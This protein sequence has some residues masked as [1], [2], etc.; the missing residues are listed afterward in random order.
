MKLRHSTDSRVQHSLLSVIMMLSKHEEAGGDVW[1]EKEK[2]GMFIKEL[3]TE[4]R[5]TQKE[6]ADMVHV[7]DKAVSKW[8][9]GLSVPALDLFR[10]LAAALDVSVVE[11]L[12]GQRHKEETIGLKQANAILESTIA[13]QKK[14]ILKKRIAFLFVSALLL[15][16]CMI[17]GRLLWNQGLLLDERGLVPADL[18]WQEQDMALDWIRYGLLLALMGITLFCGISKE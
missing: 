15:V 11:L 3:R 8:E 17:C 18:F 14:V 13:R 2:I 7:T 16:C 1:M 12:D 10:P 4:S 6:L 9:R 5:L